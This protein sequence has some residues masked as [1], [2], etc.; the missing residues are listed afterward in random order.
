M[1]VLQ[2]DTLPDGTV[3]Q[4]EEW[5][6]NYNFMPYGRTVATYPKSKVSHPGAFSPKGNVTFRCA[7]DFNSHDEAVKAFGDLVNGRKVLA[8]FRNNLTRKEYAD[9]I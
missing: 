6:E 7:F 4:I 5:H 3:V 8:D 1:K 9:C 2:K